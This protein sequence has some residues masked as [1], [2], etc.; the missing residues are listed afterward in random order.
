MSTRPTNP[1]VT[2][3]RYTTAPGEHRLVQG[4]RILGVVRLTDIPASGEG[5]RF[6][7]ERELE[8]RDELTAL[9]ADYLQQAGALQAIPADPAA[10]VLGGAS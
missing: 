4:Q 6:L 9:V 10:L 7:I 5:R 3:G 1:A 2:L 8:N